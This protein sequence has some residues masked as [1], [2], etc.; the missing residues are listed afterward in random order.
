MLY[1]FAVFVN[2]LNKICTFSGGRILSLSRSNRRYFRCF[3]VIFNTLLNDCILINNI[4]DNIL[5]DEKGHLKLTDFGLCT[6]FHWTHD[7]ARYRKALGQPHD[8]QASIDFDE[9]LQNR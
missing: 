6:G 8:R 7:S 9:S 4:P 1:R 2:F 5:I 3:S